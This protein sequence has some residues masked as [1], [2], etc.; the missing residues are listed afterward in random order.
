VV[1]L[2]KSNPQSHNLQTAVEHGV[3][4]GLSVMKQISINKIDCIIIERFR[5][6][7]MSDTKWKK[8]IDSVTDAFGHVFVNFKL[9]HSEE[10]YSTVFFTSDIRPFFREPTLY[11]EVEWVLFPAFYEDYVSQNNLKAGK[12][13]YPQDIEGINMVIG[14]IGHF[15]IE[16]TNAGIKIYAYK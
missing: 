8:L 9:I 14:E 11:K 12:R 6:S 1:L 4:L 5:V 7:L 2:R 16:K 3:M 15:E 13:H 10:I